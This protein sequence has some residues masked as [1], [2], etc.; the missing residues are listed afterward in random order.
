MYTM[1]FKKD[2]TKEQVEKK[3]EKIIKD[4]IDIIDKRDAYSKIE[5]PFNKVFEQLSDIIE[6][7]VIEIKPS[8]KKKDYEMI[9]T[10]RQRIRS[11]DKLMNRVSSTNGEYLKGL[12]LDHINLMMWDLNN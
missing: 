9:S 3:I 6:G 8:S 12:Y 10:V 2:V 7:D 11:L 5:E 1:K 4:L